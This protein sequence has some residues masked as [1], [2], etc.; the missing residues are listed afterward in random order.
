LPIVFWPPILF[1][2]VGSFYLS[3]VPRTMAAKL[4]NQVIQR[5]QAEGQDEYSDNTDDLILFHHALPAPFS[6]PAH[7]GRILRY[8]QAS[9]GRIRTVL[10]LYKKFVR[11]QAGAVPPLCDTLRLLRETQLEPR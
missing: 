7:P 6:E 4:T 3:A 8:H 9:T 10:R 11:I 1:E 2:V 5:D